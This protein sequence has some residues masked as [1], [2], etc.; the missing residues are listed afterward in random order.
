MALIKQYVNLPSGVTNIHGATR[1]IR[2]QPTSVPNVGTGRAEWWVSP[3]GT[4]NTSILYIPPATRN[5]V[6][7][8]GPAGAKMTKTKTTLTATGADAGF[9]V[10][11][12]S[13]PQVG[14]DRYVVKVSREGNRADPLT[15]PDTFQTWRKIYYTV[16]YMGA[17][18]LNLFNTIQARF[19]GAYAPAFIEVQNVVKTATLTDI[20]RADLTSNWAIPSFPWMNGGPNAIINL[21]PQGAGVL[22]DKPFHLALLVVPELY[23]LR[24]VARAELNRTSPVGSTTYLHD[25]H[26][27]A[28]TTLGFIVSASASWTGHAPV[29]VRD[30]FTLGA[31]SGALS[32]IS[33]DL[34]AVPG[35]TAWLAGAGHRYNLNYTVR[36]EDTFM[37]W[38]FAN[39]CVVRTMDGLTD[40][41]ETFTHELGHGLQQTVRQEPRWNEA[42]NPMAPDYNAFWHTDMFGGQ[43]P[44]CTF[45]AVLGPATAA[46]I[47]NGATSGQAYRWGGGGLMCTMFFRGDANV[48][49]DGKFC[50]VAC[51]PRLKRVTLDSARMT[52]RRWNFFG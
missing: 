10:N 1:Q 6:S 35:L 28:G 21:R 50:T 8:S 11:T 37:G 51:E 34:T 29:N 24:N 12:L 27:D 16:Y 38:S 22:A 26:V 44:H 19:E 48:D 42:G 30:R 7:P 20:Q 15:T 43:G 33:W 25:L 9:F 47:A 17:A 36:R 13:F 2:V 5:P 39:F 41:L 52:A 40:V 18:S 32:T 3:D 31:H 23:D 14:G 4:S 46:Q 49:P 45:N